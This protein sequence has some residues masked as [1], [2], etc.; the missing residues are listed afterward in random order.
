MR[1]IKITRKVGGHFGGKRTPHHAS[2]VHGSMEKVAFDG[3]VFQRRLAAHHH[4]QYFE[5]GASRL[6]CSL[7]S[8]NRSTFTQ[9]LSGIK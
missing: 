8:D 2:Q 3:G 5:D 7:P 6:I 4:A 9:Y 1:P